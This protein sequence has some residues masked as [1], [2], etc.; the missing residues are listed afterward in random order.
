MQEYFDQFNASWER[1]LLTWTPKLQNGHLELP[2]APGLGAD[3]NMDVVHE[4]PYTGTDMNLWDDQWH[5]RRDKI[6]Q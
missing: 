3:L 2:T 5:L 4:H 6:N 1:D